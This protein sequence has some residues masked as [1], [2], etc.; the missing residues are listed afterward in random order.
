MAGNSFGK[1]FR[2]TTFGESHGKAV[3]V[4][5]DG[6]KAG[7]E[8]CEEDINKELKRRKPGQS[9]ITSPR[10]EADN[11]EILS[12][13]FEGKTLGTPICIIVRNKDA[14][15][16]HY[17]HIK[18]IFRPGHADYT[19][20]KK[21]GI[22]DYRGGGRASGRE[23][24]GRVAAA[25]IAKKLLSE[26]GIQIVAYTKEVADIKADTIDLNEIEKNPVR[27]PD[28]KK[29]KEMEN[30][31]LKAK[32]E[33]DS[34]GGIIEI[35]I[36]GIPPGLGEPVFSRMNAEL[37]KAF[38]SIPAVK[39]VEFGTGFSSSKMKGSEMNDP[40][41]SENGEIKFESNNAG[42]TLGG[43]STGQDIIARVA[44]KPTSSIL[45]EQNTV[46]I[47][48]N[49]K[50]I[51]VTGRHDPCICPRVVPVAEAMAALVIEDMLLIQESRKE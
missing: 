7:M 15:P 32:E 33:G 11:A 2:I 44:I 26:K 28:A 40:L 46:D 24:I 41:F 36:K 34:L 10:K 50:K 6:V 39:G 13:V 8:I 4:V 20:F 16:G 27:C 14:K 30:E 25:A 1:I 23:T 21:F 12:G 19:Y 49:Q 3:G 5:L 43:I 37:A 45:K 47:Q 42:G 31:I 48:G 38:M 35:I 22:R 18:D 9:S 17:D 51:K 29:A